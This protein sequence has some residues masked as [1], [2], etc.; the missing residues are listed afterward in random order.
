MRVALSV[1]LSLLFFGTAAVSGE[2]RTWSDATGAYKIEAEFVDVQRNIVRLKTVDGKI[3]RVPLTQLRRSDQFYISQLRRKKKRE[4]TKSRE[5][6]SPS[7]TKPSSGD[8]ASDDSSADN[9]FAPTTSAMRTWTD[10]TG[11]H[12]VEAEFLSLEG[13]TLRLRRSD[14]KTLA[15]PLAKLSTADQQEARRLAAAAEDDDPFGDAAIETSPAEAPTPTAR[16]AR[17]PGEYLPGDIVAADDFG[18]RRQGRVLGGD[19]HWLEVLFD[20][21][22]DVTSVSRQSDEIELIRADP[23]AVAR[24]AVGL[25]LTRPDFSQVS[26]IVG[27]VSASTTVTPDAL[28]SQTA[29]GRRRAVTLGPQQGFFERFTAMSI[30]PDGLHALLAYTGGEDP[31]D[32]RCRLQICD[33]EA[34]R[35][36]S[37]PLE[38]RLEQAALAPGG[39]VVATVAEGEGHDSSAVDV[40]RVD[41][42]ELLHQLSW[43]PFEQSRF[44]EVVDLA[45]IDANRLLTVGRKEVVAWD[46]SQAKAIYQIQP[47]NLHTGALSAGQRR[48]ALAAGESIDLHDTETG[49]MLLQIDL[50]Q[51]RRYESLAFDPSG[52]LLA[53]RAGQ[54]LDLIN[55]ETKDVFDTLYVPSRGIIC[56]TDQEHV[57]VGGQH[58]LH[59]P[60]KMTVWQYQHGADATRSAGGWQWYLVG[61]GDPYALLPL[62]L[63]HPEVSGID[64]DQ[65]VLRSGDSVALRIELINQFAAG[66]KSIL[67]ETRTRLTEDLVE[68]GYVVADESDAVLVASTDSG[69]QKNMEYRAFGSFRG[70]TSKVSAVER[71]Y[72]LELQVGGETVW[73]RRNV[74]GPPHFLQLEEGENTSQGVARVMRP[75]TNYFGGGLPSRVI[76]PEAR[77]KRTS[78]IGL[79]GL[80]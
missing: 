60:S 59:V 15:L 21:D 77:A 40:W 35:V 2:V 61:D 13:Q 50:P 56:W 19:K 22:T 41:A 8:A 36:R 67:E 69:E 25:P 70:E 80:R 24:S 63:P 4:A 52:R 20:G 30:T 54:Q 64:D 32:E 76:A 72:L 55:L 68:A 12:R 16:P 65:L 6:A 9:P 71:I 39:N 37:L 1:L 58:L 43:K 5:K 42:K 28:E 73:Q 78:K 14:G 7:V 48:L 74:Q 27:G 45:W 49:D 66:G 17:Q 26:Q 10:R 3:A 75:S 47:P 11:R 34:G 51:P 38:I 53:A 46:A 79:N 33:L 29:L 31:H 62:K 23:N 44:D 57:L 18:K